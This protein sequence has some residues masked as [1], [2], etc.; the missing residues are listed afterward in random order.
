MLWGDKLFGEIDGHAFDFDCIRVGGVEPVIE[1]REMLVSRIIELDWRIR[2]VA[3]DGEIER[4]R[5]RAG[6]RVDS[7]PERFFGR[8]QGVQRAD[9][10]DDLGRCSLTRRRDDANVLLFAIERRVGGRVESEDDRMDILRV[11]DAFA[12]H[13]GDLGFDRPERDRPIR[14]QSSRKRLVTGGFD[15]TLESE[16]RKLVSSN[17]SFAGVEHVRRENIFGSNRSQ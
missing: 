4:Q 1:R 7:L 11:V 6:K 14:E 8:V 16:L 12:D 9:L 15:D 10:S 13:F 17:P 2:A 3:V 5:V